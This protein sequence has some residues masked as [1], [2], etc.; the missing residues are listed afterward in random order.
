MPT[1]DGREW[2]SPRKIAAGFLWQRHY[3]EFKDNPWFP[4]AGGVDDPSPY[5]R[6]FIEAGIR[7]LRATNYNKEFRRI[8]LFEM[9]VDAILEDRLNTPETTD[10]LME[11][12]AR[13]LKIWGKLKAIFTDA[14]IDSVDDEGNPLT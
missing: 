13:W 5:K 8:R 10:D 6:R 12:K 3:D 2:L 4:H 9:V 7:G 14:L 11:A 1:I